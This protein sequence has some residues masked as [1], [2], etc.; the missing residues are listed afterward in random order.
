M[1]WRMP[2]GNPIVDT[3]SGCQTGFVQYKQAI[4]AGF[5]R[6]HLSATVGD[7]VVFELS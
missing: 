4:A 1:K 6:L 2:C 3:R 7:E 5:A